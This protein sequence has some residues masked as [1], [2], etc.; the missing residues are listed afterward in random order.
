MLWFS[1]LGYVTAI[2]GI[3]PLD[4]TSAA[5]WIPNVVIGAVIAALV[6]A[7]KRG[8]AWAGALFSVAVVFTVI[9][10]IGQLWGGAPSWL[11]YDPQVVT[12]WMKITDVI[13]T[14]FGVAALSIYLHDRRR[15]AVQA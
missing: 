9:A 1:V 14:V 3:F 6:W 11:R 5:S 2:V 7:A 4:L 15:A 12:T 8:H 13:T 10:T